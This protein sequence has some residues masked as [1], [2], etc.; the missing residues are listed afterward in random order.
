M[1][2][3]NLYGYQ[4]TESILIWDWSSRSF[5]VEWPGQF[6]VFRPTK[7]FYPKGRISPD[8][9]QQVDLDCSYHHAMLLRRQKELW[10]DTSPANSFVIHTDKDPN[11]T[12]IFQHSTIGNGHKNVPRSLSTCESQNWN[13]RSFLMIIVLVLPFFLW[14]QK[15]CCCYYAYGFPTVSNATGCSGN[16]LLERSYLATANAL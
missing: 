2:D 13:T 1:K 11:A 15:I 7:T 10:L 14:Y 3:P 12:S 5:M 4:L 16:F 6:T 8:Q 9:E